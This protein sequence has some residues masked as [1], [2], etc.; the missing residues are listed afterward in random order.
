MFNIV[1]TVTTSNKDLEL[2]KRRGN[3][4][5]DGFLSWNKK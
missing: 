5:D 2:P 1:A 3:D 4:D